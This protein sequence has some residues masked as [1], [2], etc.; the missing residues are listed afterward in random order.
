MA[1]EIEASH[2]LIPYDI[3]GL[4]DEE[5]LMWSIAY[6]YEDYEGYK[7]K[8]GGRGR[9]TALRLANMFRLNGKPQGPST[10]LLQQATYLSWRLNVTPEVHVSRTWQKDKPIKYGLLH[11]RIGL[12]PSSVILETIFPPDADPVRA[13]LGECFK[14]DG[15]KAVQVSTARYSFKKWVEQNGPDYACSEA[16]WLRYITHETPVSVGKVDGVQ[17]FI[18]GYLLGKLEPTA[19]SV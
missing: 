19:K 4:S 10:D 11:E 3:Q 13:W 17:C 9:F 7:N 12:L 8:H 14:L 6:G 15:Q 2:G 5:L 16:E 1:P 18:G